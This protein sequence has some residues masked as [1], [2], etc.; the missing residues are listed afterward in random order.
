MA[1]SPHGRLHRPRSANS[2]THEPTMAP[3][4]GDT[5]GA[6][7]ASRI[8][9]LCSC[10]TAVHPAQYPGCFWQCWHG[11]ESAS[12]SAARLARR[13]P[14]EADAGNKQR[15]RQALGGP[16]S[17]ACRAAVAAG[18]TRPATCMRHRG[19][20]RRTPGEPRCAPLRAPLREPLRAHDR[21]R[22]VDSTR[23]HTI[24]SSLPCQRPA[25]PSRPTRPC[26]GLADEYLGATARCGSHRRS[27]VVPPS[28]N[29][30]NVFTFYPPEPT[31]VSARL[32]AS[33]SFLASTASF[34]L[35]CSARQQISAWGWGSVTYPTG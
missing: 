23:R 10:S 12:T 6:L 16:S 27:S 5:Q 9:A 7:A 32:T 26:A 8:R 19:H 18:T 11:N 2:R 30:T 1:A 25:H 17:D 20:G 29:D 13:C 33:L 24:S 22:P 4:K 3:P 35:L 34:S 28:R 14:L 15:H 21:N 31:R